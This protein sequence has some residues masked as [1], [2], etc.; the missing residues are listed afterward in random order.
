M[1]LRL[2]LRRH[3]GGWRRIWEARTPGTKDAKMQKDAHVATSYR[4]EASTG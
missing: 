4:H 3:N 2:L 1:L